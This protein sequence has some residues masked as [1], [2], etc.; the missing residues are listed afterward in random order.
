MEKVLLH[1]CCAPCSGAIIEWM[2]ANGYK[3][4]VYY[5]NPNIYPYEEYLV[6]KQECSRYALSLGL[7]IVD[8]DYDHSAWHHPLKDQRKLCDLCQRMCCSENQCKESNRF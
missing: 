7:E 1:T 3:P 4:T 6:R 8:A 2:L 5:C